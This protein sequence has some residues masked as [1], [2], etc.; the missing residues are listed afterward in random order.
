MLSLSLHADV[1]LVYGGPTLG[2]QEQLVRLGATAVVATPG[3]CA[4]LIHRGIRVA[5]S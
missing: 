5:P 2:S 4:R 3:R 1:A